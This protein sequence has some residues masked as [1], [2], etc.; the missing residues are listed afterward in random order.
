VRGLDIGSA[1]GAA[2]WTSL[3][4]MPRMKAAA[5]PMKLAGYHEAGERPRKCDLC[6]SLLSK[7][8]VS[9]RPSGALAGVEE[10]R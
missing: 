2:R 6:L 7:V 5:E 9:V 10:D 3:S 8:N 1:Q 4:E